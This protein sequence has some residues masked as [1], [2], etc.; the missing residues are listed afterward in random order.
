MNY[1]QIY[2]ESIEKPEKFWAEQAN[3]IEWY[4]KPEIILSE[5]ET[6]YPLWYKD[7]EL[8]ICYLAL[9]KHIQDG[10]GEQ[11]A[12]IYDSPVTQT[13]KKYSFIEVKTEVAKLAGG[14]QSLGLWTYRK[15]LGD[16]CG[17]LAGPPPCSTIRPDD[18]WRSASR[19]DSQ[20]EEWRCSASRD[21]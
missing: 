20:F 15:H 4:N 19:D 1:K 3:A 21:W 14:L 9:D 12:I 17:W 13:V 7:G 16:F 8:N 6:G 5:D 11:T 18:R 10:H 2:T